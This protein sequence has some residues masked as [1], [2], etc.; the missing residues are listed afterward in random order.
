[1]KIPETIQIA[2]LTYD[3]KK[4]APDSVELCSG[5]ANGLHSFQNCCIFLNKEMNEQ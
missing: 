4:I 3:I 2:G 1:M 5:N